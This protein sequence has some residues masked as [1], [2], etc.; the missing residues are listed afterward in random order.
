MF[1]TRP[2]RANPPCSTTLTNTRTVCKRSIDD[3]PCP[4]VLARTLTR[5]LP[6]GYVSFGR[7]DRVSLTQTAISIGADW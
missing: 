3:A 7:G 2:A 4:T 6:F 1:I 5:S